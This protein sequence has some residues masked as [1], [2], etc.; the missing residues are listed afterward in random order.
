MLT[1]N[2]ALANGTRFGLAASVWTADGARLQ[3]VAQALETGMVWANCWLHRDLRVPF[4]GVKASSTNTFR[5]QGSAA[6]DFYTWT[7]SVYLGHDL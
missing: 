2:D 7:K 4:G 1:L 5:E 3:R 6:L